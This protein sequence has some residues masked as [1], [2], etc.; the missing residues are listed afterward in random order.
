MDMGGLIAILFLLF[1]AVRFWPV[2]VLIVVGFFIKYF[3][4]HNGLW[5]GISDFVTSFF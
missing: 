3:N 2:L 4:D 1:I 5:G